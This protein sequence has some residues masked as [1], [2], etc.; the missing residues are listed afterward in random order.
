MDA[1]GDVSLVDPLAL[2]VY[3]NISKVP[4]IFRVDTRSH[5]SAVDD[6]KALYL[7][8][9]HCTAMDPDPLIKVVIYDVDW[10][11]VFVVIAAGHKH[12]TVIDLHIPG[13]PGSLAGRVP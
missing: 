1:A 4:I 6:H 11:R 9:G 7:F 2:P 12:L 13:C 10:A 3:I 8:I 5:Q